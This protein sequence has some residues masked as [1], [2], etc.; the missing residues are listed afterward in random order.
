MPEI[1]VAGKSLF[2]CFDFLTGQIMLPVGGFLTALIVGWVVP[3]NVIR[4]EFTN[5]GTVCTNLFTIFIWTI[6]VVCPVGIVIIFLNQF[7]I[8]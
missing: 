2:D 3:V 6:R 5:Y 8:I 4:D 1:A 7:G